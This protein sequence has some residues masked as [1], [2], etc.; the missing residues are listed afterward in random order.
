MEEEHNFA[1]KLKDAT[2]KKQAL[3]GMKD[4][5]VQQTAGAAM[6][7]LFGEGSVESGAGSGA[8]SGA[9]MGLKTGNPYAAVVGGI[10]GGVAGGLGASA[11]QKEAY[12]AAKAKAQAAHHTKLANIEEDKD[13]KIQGALDSMKSAFSRNFQNNRSVKL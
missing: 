3:S 2:S 8:L 7:G 10:V 5:M 9:M 11:A 4:A 12:K 1:E 13:R 6:D